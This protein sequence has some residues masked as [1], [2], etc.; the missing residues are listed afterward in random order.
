MKKLFFGLLMLAGT[1]S[2][3]Q[4]FSMLE[5]HEGMLVTANQ[6]TLRGNIRYDLPGNSVQIQTASAIKALSSFK[7]FYFEIYDEV[8][9]N[10]RQFYSI[11]YK[12]RA[13]YNAP[14]IFE[15]LYEGGL[16]LL[17]REKIVQSNQSNGN[18]FWSSRSYPVNEL[19][20]DFFFL[21]KKGKITFFTGGKPELYE[22]MFRKRDQV[23][24]FVKSNNLRV[25]ELQDLI[26]IASFY[27]SI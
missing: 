15:L 19:K 21:D 27:N 12:L 13:N 18:P 9:D 16:S 6:D 8:Y 10:Y 20:Y 4:K 14:V 24:K 3:S 25:D 7:V 5:W 26:R 22:I 1:L 17:A 11:P 2:Y 23:K